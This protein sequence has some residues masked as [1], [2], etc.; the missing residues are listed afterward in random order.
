LR[1]PPKDAQLY[2]KALV[3]RH[4]TL[5]Q[6]SMPACALLSVP[7]DVLCSL[8]IPDCRV[9]LMART[10]KR[11]RTALTARASPV[12]ITVRK[13]VLKDARLAK[14]FTSGMHQM[15]ALFRIRHFE[16]IARFSAPRCVELKLCEFEDLTFLHLRHF[17]MHNNQLRDMHLANV[18]HMLTFS[19]DLRTFEFTQQSLLAR[20]APALAYTVSRFPLLEVLDIANNFL[21]FETLGTILDNVQSST[22]STLKLSSNS[23][24]GTR[25]MVQLCRVIHTNCNCLRVLELSCLRLRS[26]AVDCLVGALRTCEL[27]E[28]LDLSRNHLPSL[29]LVAILEGTSGCRHLHSFNWSGNWLGSAGTLFLANHIAQSDAWKRSMRALRLRN[30]DIYNNVQQLT[31][32][33]AD[34]RSLHTLDISGNAVLA[35][36]V[37]AL[38]QHMRIRS[39]DISNNHISDSGMRALLRL[40]MQSNMLHELHVDGNHITTH[41]LRL[42]RKMKRTRGMKITLPAVLCFCNVCEA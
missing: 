19:H 21:I 5:Q 42:L 36:E 2:I 41:S 25:Q 4:L 13:Q 18:L 39:L 40:A 33:L 28:S 29:C 32:A 37:V 17:K 26:T 9:L 8:A 6:N 35:H 1:I 30:C 31:L 3:R 38:L 15:Q 24:E 10:C 7:D 16:C 34:C 11:L 23:C 27:L 22:L 12:H 20:H 14:R